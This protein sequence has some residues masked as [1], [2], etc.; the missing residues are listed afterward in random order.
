MFDT[1]LMT[2][3]AERRGVAMPISR[4]TVGALEDLGYSVNYAAADPYTIPAGLRARPTA[5]AAGTTP[6]RMWAMM[7]MPPAGFFASFVASDIEPEGQPAKQR[8]FARLQQ[9]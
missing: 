8:A 2:G 4:M 9:G 7:S 3:Y 5:V 6:A 1:E